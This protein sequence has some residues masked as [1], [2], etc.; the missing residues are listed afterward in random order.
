M[1]RLTLIAFSFLL[2]WAGNSVL[3]AQEAPQQIE[4][5]T[6]A[7]VVDGDTIDVL[8]GD[9]IQRVRYIGMNTPERGEPC[10]REATRANTALVDGQTVAMVRDVSETDRYGRLLRYVYVSGAFVNAQLVIDGWAESVHYPPDT[11]FA[12][13]FDY[14]EEQARAANLGCY[15]TGIFG[16]VPVALALTPLP[17]AQAALPVSRAAWNCIGN[18][19]NCGSFDTCEEL[20]SCWNACAGEPSRLDCDN[21]GQPCESMCGG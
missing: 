16:T 19:Y 21:D 20:I 3:S 17:P 14:L 7:Y 15:P 5:G 13:W 9:S 4:I 8:L 6:V 1:K 11:M 10:A 18:R 12:A 2:I